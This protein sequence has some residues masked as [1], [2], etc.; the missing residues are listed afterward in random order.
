MADDAAV[1]PPAV[2]VWGVSTF[3]VVV[4]VVV[5]VTGLF[6][7]GAAGDVLSGLDTTVGAAIYLYLWGITWWTTRRWLLAGGLPLTADR[8]AS[9]AVAVA[10]LKWGG[11]TGLLFFAG[12]LVVAGGAL[13]VIGDVGT[14]PVVVGIGLVGSP[15][16]FTVGAVV[17]GVFA[18]ADR[19]LLQAARS[20]A[21]PAGC[22]DG[23]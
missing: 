10:T 16:A 22:D 9:R 12:L 7:S 23:P 3:H 4:L 5:L 13:L 18:V 20:V 15:L 21:G 2:L 14:I 19:R 6:L 1:D 11:I 17:A 8:P